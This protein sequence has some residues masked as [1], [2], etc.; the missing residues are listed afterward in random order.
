MAEAFHS[1]ALSQALVEEGL[2]PKECR[3]IEILLPVG[4]AV[5]LRYEVY[6]EIVDLEHLAR[7]FKRAHELLKEIS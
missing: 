1:R 3:D 4:G 6:V 5:M 7:A 2:V